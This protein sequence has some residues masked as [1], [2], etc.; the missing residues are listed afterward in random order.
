MRGHG[1]SDKPEGGYRIQR[2]AKDL[3]DVLKAQG[4]DRPDVLGRSM[5]VSVMWSCLSLF[6]TERPLDRLVM[7]DQAPRVLAQPGW[8]E[9]TVRNS[10]RLFPDAASLARFEEAVRATPAAAGTKELIRGLFTGGVAEAD[11]DWIAA[12]NRKLPRAQAAH[13]LHDHCILDWRSEVAAVR[14]PTLAI[15]AEASIF[16]QPRSAGLRRRSPAPWSRYFQRPTAEATSCSSRTP[17]GSMLVWRGSWGSREHLGGRICDAA[18][19]GAFARGV[20]PR[21]G[22]A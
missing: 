17:P 6:G 5:G 11:L 19:G 12:E 14:N 8:D 15:G 4:L 16:P 13:L 22:Q 20:N 9:A 3:F 10:G 18:R 21:C 7:V 1:E 2:L